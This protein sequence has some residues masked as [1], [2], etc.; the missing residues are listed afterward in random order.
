MTLS[1]PAM[2]P[3]RLGGDL[4]SMFTTAAPRVRDEGAAYGPHEVDRDAFPAARV[5]EDLPRAPGDEIPLVL[6]RYAALRYWLLRR[7][8]SEPALTRHARKTAR[9]YLAAL[10][11][12]AHARSLGRLVEA[13]STGSGIQDAAIMAEQAGHREGAYAL[14]RAG[15]T[16]ARRRS[17]IHTAAGLAAAIARLLA[18]SGVDGVALWTRR[19]DRLRRLTGNR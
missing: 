4:Q 19:A 7:E 14:L 17:D 5:L 18:A 16:A 15:Y 3:D 11:D 13:G 2:A 10:D 6:A 9:A 8:G 1:H 12:P